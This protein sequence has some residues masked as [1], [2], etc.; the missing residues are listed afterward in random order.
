MVKQISIRA[1][2]QS[3]NAG[4]RPADMAK[5]FLD[6]PELKVAA[7]GHNDGEARGVDPRSGHLLPADVARAHRSQQQG[8]PV[9]GFDYRTP[10]VI[11][12]TKTAMSRSWVF[13]FTVR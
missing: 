12:V 1:Y 13:V 5:L 8:E 3:P 7:F 10:A 2:T 9:R 11:K 6:N 4:I